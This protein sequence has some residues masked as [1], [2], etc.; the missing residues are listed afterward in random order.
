MDKS[1]SGSIVPGTT[2]IGNQWDD[3]VTTIALPLLFT[4]MTRVSPASICRPT[5]NAQFTT[6]DTTQ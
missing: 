6:T 5:G 4:C 3:T 2:D 1:D